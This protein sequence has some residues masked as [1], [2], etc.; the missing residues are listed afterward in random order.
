MLGAAYLLK[1]LDLQAQHA[2]DPGQGLRAVGSLIMRPRRLHPGVCLAVPT[3]ALAPLGYIVEP[4][5]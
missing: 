3:S 2:A 5:V 4:G 1:H